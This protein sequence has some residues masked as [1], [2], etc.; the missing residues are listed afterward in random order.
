MSRPLR[1]LGFAGSLRRGSYNR[2]LLRAAIELAPDDLAIDEFEIDE[3]PLYDAD[4]EAQGDPAA[5]T[6][7]KDAIRAADAI[8]VVTPE[9]NYGLPGVLKNA[10]DWASRPARDSPLN[11]KLAGIMGATPGRMGT[12]RAQLQLRQSFVFTETYAML[13]PEVLVTG[14]R[15]KFDADGRLADQATRDFVGRFL[16]AFADWLRRMGAGAG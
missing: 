1:V 6:V 5:V 13:R 14:A 9:Y 16:V 2:A 15:E 10:L 11:G 12:T 7:F 4:V 8:L 3:I